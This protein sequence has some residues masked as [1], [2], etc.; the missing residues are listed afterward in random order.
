MKAAVCPIGISPADF[1]F[2]LTKDETRFEKHLQRLKEDFKDYRLILGV[3]RIDYTKGL[4]DKLKAFDHFLRT[5]SEYKGKAVLIQIGIPSRESLPE[6][7]RVLAEVCSLVGEINSRHGEQDNPPKFKWRLLTTGCSGSVH[8]TPVRFLHQ[9]VDKC[10]LAALYA[11]SDVCLVTAIRDGMNLVSFEY[12]TCQQ[13]H[14]GVLLLGKHI[15]AA[16]TLRGAVLIDP[17]NSEEVSCS[18][19]LALEMDEEERRSRQDI[20]MRTV[21]KQTS[22]AW[23]NAFV[24]RLREA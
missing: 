22:A 1:N 6:T 11:A 13:E 8:Y 20:N 23:G 14:N 19:K 21:M 12:V 10:H 3:D 24:Q 15:G 18:I 2:A 7:K 16:S 17:K 9:S 5:Y 4:P